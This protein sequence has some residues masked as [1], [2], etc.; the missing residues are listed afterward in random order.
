MLRLWEAELGKKRQKTRE[1]EEQLR[2]DRAAMDAKENELLMLMWERDQK[3]A[4]IKAVDELVS[5]FLEAE[6]NNNFDAQKAM[7]NQIVA[8]MRNDDGTGM[9]GENIGEL[10]NAENRQGGYCRK[11]R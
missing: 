7:M 1:M 4:E 11:G 6:D 8:L 2:A 5:Q 3:L 10:E 9:N